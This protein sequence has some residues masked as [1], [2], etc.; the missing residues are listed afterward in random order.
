MSL[1]HNSFDKGVI[2]AHMHSEWPMYSTKRDYEDD[3][4]KQK[5]AQTCTHN[6]STPS[7]TKANPPLLLS[8]VANGVTKTMPHTTMMRYIKLIEPKKPSAMVLQNIKEFIN[9]LVS[10]IPYTMTT[11]FTKINY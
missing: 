8:L 10:P 9:I 5:E 3:H 2:F 6:K 11:Y 7:T 1:V 4:D